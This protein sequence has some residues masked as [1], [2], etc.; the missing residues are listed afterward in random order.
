MMIFYLSTSSFAMPVHDVI[1]VK[2]PS[3]VG[4]TAFLINKA[5][6]CSSSLFLSNNKY[7]A[8]YLNKV[9]HSQCHIYS[10]VSFVYKELSQHDS[11]PGKFNT[12]EIK[13]YFLNYDSDNPDEE[14]LPDFDLLFDSFIKY[15]R[16]KENNLSLITNVNEIYIDNY[17]LYNLNEQQVIK[18][19]CKKL[20]IQ[21]LFLAGDPQYND[22]FYF[23]C[24]KKN[25]IPNFYTIEKDFSP[26]NYNE[27]ILNR[28]C[29]SKISPIALEIM[30]KCFEDKELIEYSYNNVNEQLNNTY[31]LYYFSNY[32]EEI[33]YVK[34]LAV[35]LHAENP[36]K[37][38]TITGY[39]KNSVKE[40][41]Q[42]KCY[43][44]YSD[45]LDVRSCHSFCC[46][47]YTDIL[48]YINVLSLSYFKEIVDEDY[49]RAM[50]YYSC[51][52]K[53][54]DEIYLTTSQPI[55]SFNNSPLNFNIIGDINEGKSSLL[56]ELPKLKERTSELT[57]DMFKAMY[58]DSISFSIKSESLK[59]KPSFEHDYNTFKKKF[60]CTNSIMVHTKDKIQIR[61][62]YNCGQDM[63]IFTLKDINLLRYNYYTDKQ[64][65]KYLLNAIYEFMDYRITN[66]EIFLHDIDIYKLIDEND[67]LYKDIIENNINANSKYICSKNKI[68]DNESDNSS[69]RSN[70]YDELLSDFDELR[71][72]NNNNSSYS[73]K[74]VEVVNREDLLNK[75]S[76]IYLNLSSSSTKESTIVIYDPRDKDNDNRLGDNDFNTLEADYSEGSSNNKLEI[77]KIELRLKNS[78]LKRKHALGKQFTASE[79]LKLLEEGLLSTL[80][81][82]VI[83]YK[84][85]K[86]RLVDNS[87]TKKIKNNDSLKI[88]KKDLVEKDR[89]YNMI[90][91][92]FNCN[93]YSILCC[94]IIH[95]YILYQFS[96]LLL[97]NGSNSPL[98]YQDSS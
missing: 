71:N 33:N 55:Q 65:A 69:N 90:G 49:Q 59:F 30:Q 60:S 74:R 62:D 8:R 66:D 41:H 79:Y 24:K 57:I 91:Y 52:S 1:A 37:K 93:E 87:K 46:R 10:I 2:G 98:H 88:E 80:F 12:P 35:K 56:Y 61:V 89:Q 43:E 21:K 5:K 82:R 85:I 96:L 26:N 19:I 14:E 42:W 15:F 75:G 48:I 27:I 39:K 86:K 72:S 23:D 81:D 28:L 16:K 32:K 25:K 58:T 92:Y 11:I 50:L 63:L 13:K 31:D 51:F 64:I 29:N 38:I 78:A 44:G 47:S 77:H 17:N 6:F 45:W 34:D 84:R 97:I 7:N 20:S 67:I 70:D 9:I 54:N 22:I 4:K 3:G 53:V 73:S 68:L 83:E 18:L 94:L 76:T 36:N 40:L 95:H